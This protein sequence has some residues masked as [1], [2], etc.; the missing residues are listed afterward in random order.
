MVGSIDVRSAV[1]VAAVA[2]AAAAALAGCGGGGSDDAPPEGSGVGKAVVVKPGKLVIADSAAPDSLDPDGPSA[3]VVPNLTA[4]TNAYDG[5]VSH[6]REDNSKALGGGTT[7]DAD[8]LAPGLASSWTTADETTTVRLRKGVKSAQG[9]ELTSADVVWSY[10]RAKGLNATAGF[11]YSVVGGITDVR[12]RGKYSV[13]FRTKRPSPML[14]V[15]LAQPYT[16]IYDSTEVKK[17]ATAK[18]KWASKWLTTHTAG[19]GAYTVS[20]MVPGKSLKLSPASGYWGG[21]AENAIEMISIPD[22]ANRYVALQKGDINMALN[23]PPVQLQ[24]AEKAE[25][26]HLFRVRGNGLVQAFPNFRVKPFQNPKVRQ[27]LQYATPQE[28]IVKRVY[29]GFG[30]PIRSLATPYSPGYTDRHW[31]YAYDVEKAKELMQEAGYADG[32]DTEL[33]Y[34]S[35]SP[36]L[37]TLATILQSS[38]AQIGVNVKLV[39]RPATE[40]VTRAFGK[41]DLPLYLTD[42]ATSV[43]PD[44]SNLGALYRTGGFANVNNYSSKPFDA[45]Y[46]TSVST[47]DAARR[48][49]AFDRLQRVAAA[50]PPSVYAAGLESVVAASSNVTGYS[51]QPDQGQVFGALKVTAAR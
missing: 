27:A 29:L 5:L 39:G 7:I 36:T 10:E 23:L 33:H 22:P 8:G 35:E 11:V 48:A 21:K 6:K 18:D 40:L 41:K 31:P 47:N 49:P 4:Y 30:F 45:A 28:E 3:S 20:S 32:V 37:G 42:S 24:E 51:W 12:A 44:I 43:I 34:S 16:K 46:E 2:A 25:A 17:H 50:D 1:V 13:E 19:F 9:N 38:W 26:V 14:L 15:S